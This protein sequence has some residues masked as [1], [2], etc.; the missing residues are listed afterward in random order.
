MPYFT[1]WDANV[2]L[3][4]LSVFPEEVVRG[5]IK[6]VKKTHEDHIKQE[7]LN[8]W[9]ESGANAYEWFRNKKNITREF[10]DLWR[11]RC[12]EI[13][14]KFVVRWTRSE[15]DWNCK[16]IWSKE[17]YTD[18]G[19]GTSRAGYWNSGEA[20]SYSINEKETYENYEDSEEELT[21]E[22]E[23]D[24][25]WERHRRLYVSQWYENI[26]EG[27]YFLFFKENDMVSSDYVV[28]TGRWQ[29]AQDLLTIDGGGL[30]ETPGN[31]I[32]HIDDLF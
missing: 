22:Y 16:H 15:W 4:L 13:R 1:S 27:R 3:C 25:T 6:M 32:E 17:P 9:Q 24:N 18:R 10:K 12:P 11:W 29:T 7:S 2:F 26:H 14:R 28:T 31:H 21:L 19:E 30:G 8:H 23:R 5:M 20:W